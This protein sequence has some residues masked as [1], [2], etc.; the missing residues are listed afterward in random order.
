[1]KIID[2]TMPVARHF[3]WPV[4]RALKGDFAK[5]DNFQV[6]HLSMVVHGFTHVDSP[7]HIDPEGWTTSDMSLEQVTGDA[8]IVDLS[9]I[10]PETAIAAEL[11][12]DKGAHIRAGDIVVMKTCWDR[13][14]SAQTP[15]FW[16]TAP[17]MTREACDWLLAKEIKALAVD[18]PQDY[19]IRGLLGGKTAPMSDFVTHDVLLRNGVVLIEYVCNLA[20]VSAP[21]T[22]LF[23]LPLKLPD[24]DGAPARVI[25]VEPD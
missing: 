1:M 7:R 18:F 11:V 22:T 23:A 21:R 16:T 13:V 19:P 9:G 25:A 24:S 12:A 3:R 20:A 4:E 14:H 5:G 2:L 8:A 10:A 17:Y 15:E 6:T